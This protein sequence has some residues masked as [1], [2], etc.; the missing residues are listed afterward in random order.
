[1]WGSEV[2]FP[3]VWLVKKAFGSGVGTCEG[4][5]M[6][7]R[8]IHLVSALMDSKMRFSES[9]ELVMPRKFVLLMRFWPTGW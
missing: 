4:P 1:M 9:A 3:K 6:F 8:T 2:C 5:C 7:C